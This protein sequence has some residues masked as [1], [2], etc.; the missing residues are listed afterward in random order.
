MN[1]TRFKR[2]IKLGLIIAVL[3]LTTLLIAWFALPFDASAVHRFPEGTILLDRHG[4]TI[5]RTLGPDDEDCLTAPLDSD[6]WAAK[7]LIAAE[8]K[9]F[10]QHPGIDPIAIARSSVYNL[11]NGR[12]TTGASTI[13]TQVIRMSTPRRRTLLTKLTE[14]F[15]ATQ[16]ETELDKGSIL[17]NYLNRA[18]FGGNVYGLESASR[19]YF[20]KSA[21]M[22]SL[23]EAALLMGLPQSPSRYRPDRHLERALTRRDYVLERMR[24]AEMITDG[25]VAQAK[26]QALTVD[27]HPLPASMPHFS[28]WVLARHPEAGAVHTSLDPELQQL[29]TQTLARHHEALARR[30]IHSGAIV[31]IETQ[32]GKLRAMVGSP[33]PQDSAHGGQTNHALARRSPGSTLK[34]FITAMAIDSGRV[35]PS[36]VIQDAPL[37]YENY[38][39]SNFDRRFAGEVDVREALVRSLNIPFLHL[40]EQLGLET[41][42]EQ[43]RGLGFASLDHPAAHYGLSLALGT[44]EVSLLELTNAYAC[45]ARGGRYR[46]TGFLESGHAV[47]DEQTFFSP[48][49]AYLVSDILAGDERAMAWSGHAADVVLPKAAWKTGTSNGY[50]DAWT[51][52]YNPEYV[53]GV[54]IGNSD[55]SPAES[56]IG[57]RA[58]APVASDL[59]RALYPEGDGPWF[60]PPEAI[61]ERS[62]CVQTGLPASP[63]CGEQVSGPYIRNQSSHEPCRCGLQLAQPLRILSPAPGAVIHFADNQTLNLETASMEPVYW[64]VNGESLGCRVG[65]VEW[66]VQRGWF[67]ARCVSTAGETTSLAFQVR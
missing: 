15:R 64:F 22:L 50:R 11:K 9:R 47:R 1:R 60:S 48:A 10:H 51:I 29:A 25:Q 63:R 8:D 30:G 41:F 59:L 23:A 26:A 35:T 21:D 37:L 18:P 40:V 67:E 54:W 16:M 20:G 7:A 2:F 33:D 27:W 38:T 45:L 13:S 53:I 3:G 46:S 14:A 6:S 43:L 66:A 32:S 56:L 58:A 62:V 65:P 19:R 12:V 36:T 44:A 61:A 34:P 42:H 5:R 39:P 55:N 17:Q 24:A 49:T 28:E 52:A 4:E 57:T 31:I